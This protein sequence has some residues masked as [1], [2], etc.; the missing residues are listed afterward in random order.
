VVPPFDDDALARLNER[1]SGTRNG[2]LLRNADVLAQRKR[3]TD[4]MRL[5]A[6]ANRFGA[7]ANSRDLALSRQ[8]Y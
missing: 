3:H 2:A 4:E 8:G 5:M 7:A 1:G 6:R